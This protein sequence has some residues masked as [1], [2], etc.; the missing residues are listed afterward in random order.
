MNENFNRRIKRMELGLPTVGSSF[1]AIDSGLVTGSHSLAKLMAEEF[2]HNLDAYD[3]AIDSVYNS[4]HIGGSH[5]HHLIDGQHSF[6]GSLKAVSNVKTDDSFLTELLQASEHL[7]RDAT[8]V[9]GVNPF[10][11]LTENQFEQMA[12]LFQS[13][14]ISK[15]FLADALTANGP[16]LIGG[17]L[18]LISS[19]ILGRKADPAYLSNLSGSFLVSSIASANPFLLPIAASGLVYSIY[20]AEDKKTALMSAGKGSLISGGA[21]LVGSLVGGPVIINCIA[22]VGTAVALRYLLNNPEHAFNK[23]Q[24]ILKPAKRVIGKMAID[25][26]SYGGKI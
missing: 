5:Y 16:E 11:S 1:V 23:V 6:L 19:L 21:L 15:M 3:K 4:T 20:K 18:A 22:A 12:G 17:S 24:E 13:I 10:F 25:S 14:G 26:F 2:N 9:S 8:S 7:L